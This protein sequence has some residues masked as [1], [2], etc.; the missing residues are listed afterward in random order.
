[1][2]VSFLDSF[3]IELNAMLCS[4]QSILQK[5][6]KVQKLLIGSCPRECQYKGPCLASPN[7]TQRR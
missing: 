2:A 5:I 6:K 7:D 1:M 4:T 3:W